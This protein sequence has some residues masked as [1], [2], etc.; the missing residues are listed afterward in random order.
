MKSIFG[1][2]TIIVII[3]T[4]PFAFAD[5]VFDQEVKQNIKIQIGKDGNVHVIHEISDFGQ[6]SAKL[7]FLDGTR[8]IFDILCILSC[9]Y[10]FDNPEQI[11]EES[12]YMVFSQYPAFQDALI[13]EYDLENVMELNNGLWK[14]E[15]SS[16][17]H[18]E[19][20]F[21]ESVN[22]IFFDGSAIDLTLKNGFA[23][24]GYCTMVL[25][26]FDDDETLSVRSY[27]M[28]I[29]IQSDDEIANFKIINNN[30]ISFDTTKEKQL[31]VVDIPREIYTD[32]HGLY[33]TE[34]V[35]STPTDNDRL[36]IQ[37][38]QKVPTI[39]IVVRSN[40]VGT[41]MI[42]N[43]DMS[44]A[45]SQSS[46]GGG[47]LIATAAYGSEMAP[48]VQFLREIRDNT[49]LQ[50]QSGTSFMTAFNT[51]YYTFSPTIADYEREN[52]VFKE[53]VKIGLTPLL[54]SLTILNYV[55]I[56]TEQEM[57][58]YGI[59]IIMLNIGMYFV[60]P[61]IVIIALKNRRK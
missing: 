38:I 34:E 54:T 33:I 19:F 50:T 57:L 32:S 8:S 52:P 26:F 60:A 5:I 14:W 30:S 41:V 21:D 55:D 48:Q 46:E 27:D 23:C 2:L 59:G 36:K 61:A 28:G 25:E 35:V 17:H 11:F 40:I 39:G 49:V 10:E 16:K 42:T 53:A 12:N 7:K 51:F 4:M 37:T 3:T 6:N 1:I 18:P 29:S 47:C 20:Y 13:V 56:D 31:S 9:P 44:E 45:K 43:L 22:L 58:G 24:S 15:F